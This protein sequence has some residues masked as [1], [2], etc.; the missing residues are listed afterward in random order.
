MAEVGHAQ[1]AA[2]AKKLVTVEDG[3]VP[4]H[5]LQL[6]GGLVDAVATPPPNHKLA[7]RD[8]K[9]TVDDGV[10]EPSPPVIVAVHGLTRNSRYSWSTYLVPPVRFFFCATHITHAR[11]R[12]ETLTLL[13]KPW[14]VLPSPKGGTGS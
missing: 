10:V 6:T 13:P 14:F 11:A 3:W 2:S 5:T 4:C 7:F 1:S 8:W 9:P 12:S